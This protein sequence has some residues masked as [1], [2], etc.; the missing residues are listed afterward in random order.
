MIPSKKRLFTNIHNKAIEQELSKEPWYALKPE[1][2]V[3]QVEDMCDNLAA[4]LAKY[5]PIDQRYQEA[6]DAANAKRKLPEITQFNVAVVG[7]QGIGKSS[8]INALLDRGL[9]D[10]SGSSRA[11][12]AYATILEYKKGAPDETDL[13]DVS[14]QFFSETEVRHCINEQVDRWIEVH[15]GPQE[16]G[17]SSL[18]QDDDDEDFDQDNSGEDTTFHSRTRDISEEASRAADTAEEFFQII[19]NVQEHVECGE[20][21]KNELY[22]TNINERGFSALCFDAARRMFQDMARK[23]Q[24]VS[25]ERRK[26]H[27]TNVPDKTLWEQ[28]AAIKRLWPFV[29]AVTIATGHILLRNGLRLFDIPGESLNLSAIPQGKQ[30]RVWRYEPASRSSHQP[31]PAARRL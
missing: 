16:A 14:V 13:S 22:H 3:V 10:R 11:C 2:I 19:F 17:W 25:L 15:P 29:K 26:A 23:K 24:E 31:L 6:V 27:F 21:L 8:V 30:I 28:T 20:W 9:L 7:E 18:C 12:T 1:E 5:A 4:S